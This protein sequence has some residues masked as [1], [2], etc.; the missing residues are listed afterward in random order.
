MIAVLTSDLARTFVT[1]AT[2]SSWMMAGSLSMARPSHLMA[3][4]QAWKLV[5]G[6][7]G[8]VQV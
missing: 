6:N 1:I 3:K 8:T 2:N 7:I 5:V 4:V